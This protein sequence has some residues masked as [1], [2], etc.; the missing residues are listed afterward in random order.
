[1]PDGTSGI[2]VGTVGTFIATITGVWAKFNFVSKADLK[3][4]QTQC[5]KTLESKMA[6]INGNVADIKKQLN[7]TQEFVVNTAKVLGAVEQYMKNHSG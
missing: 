4:H 2:I 6:S 3:D 5:V 1:M 7:T